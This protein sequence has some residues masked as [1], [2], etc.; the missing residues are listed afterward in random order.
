MVRGC[1]LPVFTQLVTHLVQVHKD[2]TGDE[3]NLVVEP[4]VGDLRARRAGCQWASLV[5]TSVP[6]APRCRVNGVIGVNR[7]IEGITGVC[8]N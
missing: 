6:T 8:G 5:R 2:G 7:V 4:V 3:G 1:C